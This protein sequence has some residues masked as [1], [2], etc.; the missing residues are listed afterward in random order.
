MRQLTHIPP[1]FTQ[2][3]FFPHIDHHFRHRKERQPEQQRPSRSGCRLPH[4]PDAGPRLVR[5]VLHPLRPRDGEEVLWLLRQWLL[6][7]ARCYRP[8]LHAAIR[9][10]I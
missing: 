1:P 10:F 5:F 4:F 7:A 2:I 3:P 8:H 9:Q 6:A